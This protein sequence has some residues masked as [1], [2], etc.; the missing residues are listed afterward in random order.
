MQEGI[1]D[2]AAIQRRV[3]AEYGITFADIRG[4]RRSQPIARARQM[5][6]WLAWKETQKTMTQIARAFDRHHT[7]V[8][9]AIKK[10]G[11]IAQ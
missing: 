10:H 4:P 3:A 1:G 8:L 11:G 2:I 9:H 5:A 6:M 7:T